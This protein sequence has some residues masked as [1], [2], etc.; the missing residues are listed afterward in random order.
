V[1]TSLID[2]YTSL[3][4][5]VYSQK[6]VFALLLG[7]GISQGAAIPTGWEI[8]KNL[9]VKLAAQRKE[10]AGPEPDKWYKSTFGEEPDYSKL[11]LDLSADNQS[12]R[13]QLLKPYFEPTEEE[14]E[15]G[16]K[17]PTKGHYAVAKL[18]RDGYIRAVLT[19]NFDRL[20]ETALSEMGISPTVISTDDGLCGMIP[21]SH[22]KH[23]I[24]KLH[25]DYHDARIKN[26][27]AELANYSSA[28]NGFLSELLRDFGLIVCGWSAKW[29]LALRD[30][31]CGHASRRFPIYFA[32]RG[33]LQDEALAL[34]TARNAIT[35]KASD[36]N[37]FFVEIQ[38]RIE[39]LEKIDE[40]N[41]PLSPQ[42]A[43]TRMKKIISQRRSDVEAW[44]MLLDET[45]NVEKEV[46]SPKFAIDESYNDD[47]LAVKLGQLDSSCQALIRLASLHA[48][49][50]DDSTDSF[51]GKIVG[52]LGN[53][54]QRWGNPSTKGSLWGLAGYPAAL[55]MYAAGASSIA[56]R[57][58]GT[59][60]SILFKNI[61]TT[62]ERVDD[63]IAAVDLLCDGL[64][65]HNLTGVI[66][67]F[68]GRPSPLSWHIESVVRDALLDVIGDVAEIQRV[69]DQ[70][71][72][73]TALIEAD[74]RQR[75]PRREACFWYRERFDECE[76]MARLD[77]GYGLIGALNKEDFFEDEISDF[78]RGS[79][80]VK[81]LRD[82][83]R[84][85]RRSC[86]S[87]VN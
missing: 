15:S 13:Q 20:L 72:I 46:S 49:W 4:F 67:E 23:L 12:I 35:V 11:L 78:E 26:T 52:I 86:F 81:R 7:S 60:K 18:M 24:V 58:Y 14:E 71:E 75:A 74:Y 31:I 53:R 6:G 38:E 61:P 16:L 2:P 1:T 62:R 27:P 17:R 47:S 3:A 45:R 73:V 85:A 41:H 64:L 22:S 39:A 42:V 36:A 82:I 30:A 44:E 54:F 28:M 79:A 84:S 63:S 70:F 83:V 69:F 50:A 56:A 5:S 87:W 8:T 21:L 77:E 32:H 59:L 48:Y 43:A 33:K 19:T 37:E 34:C 25:G 80:L 51:T 66:K 29:D 40:R 76:E 55:V 57:K 9:I 10:D 65:F 68:N